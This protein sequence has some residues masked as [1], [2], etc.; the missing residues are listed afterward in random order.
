MNYAKKNEPYSLENPPQAPKKKVERKGLAERRGRLSHIPKLV[1]PSPEKTQRWP[2]WRLLAESG[3][4]REKFLRFT[5][6]DA[7]EID[8]LDTLLRLRELYTP[9]SQP[10]NLYEHAYVQLVAEAVDSRMYKL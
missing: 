3:Y 7:E 9:A 10:R 5:P 1:L 2:E 6:E 8:D 4:V